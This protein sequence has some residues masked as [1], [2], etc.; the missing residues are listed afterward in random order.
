MKK[1]LRNL[2]VTV[3]T[4]C[5]TLSISSCSADPISLH[6]DSYN[7]EKYSDII[8]L[9][10]YAKDKY[11]AGQLEVGNILRSSDPKDFGSDPDISEIISNHSYKLTVRDENTVII[12]TDVVFHMAFGYVV[13]SEKSLDTYQSSIGKRYPRLDIPAGMGYDDSNVSIERYEGEL[14]GLYLYYFNAGL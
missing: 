3:M 5:L 7:T 11:D 9:A 1:H 13:T 6:T 2:F 8:A 4:L 10:N 12:Q 14:D